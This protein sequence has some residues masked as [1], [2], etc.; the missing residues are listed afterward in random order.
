MHAIV[1]TGGH[2]ALN[3]LTV[4]ELKCMSAASNCDINQDINQV[5]ILQI[6]R[7]SVRI[8]ENL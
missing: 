7:H 6:T 1:H 8:F 5:A 3:G 4:L 2:G